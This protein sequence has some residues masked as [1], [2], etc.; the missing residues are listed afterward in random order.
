MPARKNKKK[1][2]VIPHLLSILND[3]YKVNK[4]GVKTPLTAQETESLSDEVTR[5][6]FNKSKKWK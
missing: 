3:G 2:L 5:L 1:F 6:V 4:S